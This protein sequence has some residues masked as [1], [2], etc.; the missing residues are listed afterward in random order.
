MKCHIHLLVFWAL[1]ENVMSLHRTKATIVGLFD[2]SNYVNKWTVIEKLG[3][4][5]LMR[6][7]V[8]QTPREEIIATFGQQ[9][10]R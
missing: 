6:N 9:L 1:F 7:L 5:M 10:A 8:F 4:L 2:L 3:N